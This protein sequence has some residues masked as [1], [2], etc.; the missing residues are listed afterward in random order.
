MQFQE[1]D[2]DLFWGTPLWLNECQ[3]Y[4]HLGRGGWGMQKLLCHIDERCN[5][6]LISV[7][8]SGSLSYP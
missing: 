3:S 8:S 7:R 5:S 4:C 1:R 2:C 6:L